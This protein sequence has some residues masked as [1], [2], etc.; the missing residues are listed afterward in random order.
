M[1]YPATYSERLRAARAPDLAGPGAQSLAALYRAG[2]GVACGIRRQDV[3]G[4]TSVANQPG[5]R[6]FC[7]NDATM[8]FASVEKMEGWLTKGGGRGFFQLFSG[9]KL[10]GY[11]WTGAETCPELPDSLTTFAVRLNAGGGFTGQGLAHHF[12]NVIVDASV[13]YYGACN[14]GL[15]TWQSNVAAVKSYERAGAELITSR[16]DARPTL[17]AE[18]DFLTAAGEAYVR[19][20]RSYMQFTRTFDQPV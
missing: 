6:E 8:R 16:A 3:S 15:E 1:N 9:A 13:A 14:I 11:G 2:Y 20:T 18:P 17:T 12:A 4:V 5:V 10:A 7:P 19:D